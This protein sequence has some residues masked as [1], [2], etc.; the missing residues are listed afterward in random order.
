MKKLSLWMFIF[1]LLLISCTT[2]EEFK[3]IDSFSKMSKSPRIDFE[4][5]ENKIFTVNEIDSILLIF[6]KES[7]FDAESIVSVNEA[8]QSTGN[9]PATLVSGNLNVTNSSI[10]EIREV[11]TKSKGTF[12][13]SVENSLMSLAA[14]ISLESFL[15]NVMEFNNS[16]YD[17]MI[18]SIELYE[19]TIEANASYN[20]VDKNVILATSLIAKTSLFYERKRKD[21]DWDTSVGNKDEVDDLTFKMV[22]MAL[23]A[24]NIN[25]NF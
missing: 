11:I 3:E 18:S 4:Y 24:G 1:P 8:I 2:E 23:L 7:N 12:E 16:D 17:S 13:L 9:I 5:T 6:Y 14:K 21:K 25:N 15:E 22:R 19:S 20:T 10:N